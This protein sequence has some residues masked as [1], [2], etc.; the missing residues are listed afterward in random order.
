MKGKMEFS[1][2]IEVFTEMTSTYQLKRN[3]NK[4]LIENGKRLAKVFLN[5]IHLDLTKNLQYDRLTKKILRRIIRVDSNTIDI[6]CHEGDILSFIM[7]LAPGG[8]HY[9]FEPIPFYY[10]GIKEKFNG[11]ASIYPYALSNKTGESS[12]HYVKNAPAF[13]GIKKRKYA[14]SNPDIEKIQVKLK[15]LDDVLDASTRIDF[16]KIDVEGAE[17]DVLKGSE[18]LLAANK[19]YIIFEF[20]LGASEYYGSKPGELY[21][22]ITNDIGLK[23]SLLDAFLKNDIPL[24]K[25]DLEFFY[26]GKKEYYFIAHP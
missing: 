12:F 21:E 14:I 2:Y 22:F 19:P 9:G 3:K 11:N 7:K 23:L 1:S 17:M 16:L 8:N 6:G 25:E 24:S 10:E 26:Y 13:S 15:K 4:L 20:G 5:K 18:K